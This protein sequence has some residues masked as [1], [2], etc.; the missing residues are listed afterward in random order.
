MAT[1]AQFDALW[2]ALPLGRG[3]SLVSHDSNG[4]AALNKPAGVLSHPNA[5]GDEPRS[6][7]TVRYHLDGEYYEWTPASGAAPQ[8]LWLLNR[9]DSATS[10]VILVAADEELAREIRAHFKRRQVNK[11]YHALVFGS[12]HQRSELWKDMIATTRQ[13]AQVR[14]VAGVGRVPAECRMTLVRRGAGDARVSLLRLEP[15]TGRSHQLRV[16]CAKRQLPIVGD[17]TYGDFPANRAFAKLHRNK[18]LFLHS[19]ST[20]FEY[21]FRGRT[22]SFSAEA[23]LPEEFLAPL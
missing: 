1:S 12:P 7:L 6:L 2:A 17:Q 21:E 9:L 13:G 15:Q 8:R 23:P 18:R 3:V 5:G 10:G 14:S 4:L 22:F 16:Q 11:T 19:L 20:R